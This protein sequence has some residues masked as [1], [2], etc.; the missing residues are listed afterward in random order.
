MIR[1]FYFLIHGC[2][3]VWENDGIFTYKSE[4]GS[5]TGQAVRCKKCGHRTWFKC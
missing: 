2:F 1:L 3:H 5:G 4:W